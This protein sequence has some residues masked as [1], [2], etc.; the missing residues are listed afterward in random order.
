M[1][2]PFQRNNTFIDLREVKINPVEWYTP[3]KNKKKVGLVGG[4]VGLCLI[5]PC[6]NWMLVPMFKLLNKYPMFLYK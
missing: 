2:L 4:F 3:I 6:T 1:K 5:T